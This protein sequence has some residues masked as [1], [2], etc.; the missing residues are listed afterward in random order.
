MISSTT[1]QLPLLELNIGNIASRIVVSWVFILAAFSDVQLLVVLF[2]I[3]TTKPPHFAAE[4]TPY[5][6]HER[7]LELSGGLSITINQT[8]LSSRVPRL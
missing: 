5:Q 3:A 2:I 1:T 6:I 7:W 8:P 4:S